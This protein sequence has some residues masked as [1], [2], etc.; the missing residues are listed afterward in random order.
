M[1]ERQ[2]NE[3]DIR[4]ILGNPDVVA[5]YPDDKPYPSLLVLGYIHQRPLHVVIARNQAE[6]ETIVITVYEPDPLK[7]EPGFKRRKSK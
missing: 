3:E 2:I 1:F 5:E 6:N 4:K 7:W